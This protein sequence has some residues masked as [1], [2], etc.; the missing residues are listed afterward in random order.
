MSTPHHV[1]GVIWPGPLHNATLCGVFKPNRDG[2]WA[3]TSRI[4]CV[5]DVAPLRSAAEERL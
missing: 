1:E 2:I 3:S 5:G 4:A